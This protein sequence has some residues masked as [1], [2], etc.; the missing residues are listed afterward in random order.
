M[1]GLSNLAVLLKDQH[2]LAAAR[3]LLERAVGICERVLGPDDPASLVMAYSNSPTARSHA[4][5]GRRSG[6][7]RG[8]ARP[9][10][11]AW[12]ATPTPSRRDRLSAQAARPGAS[13]PA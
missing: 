12:R 3:P 1:D 2:G 8:G 10:G 9:P 5:P 13:T 4:I 11:A 7:R 6:P